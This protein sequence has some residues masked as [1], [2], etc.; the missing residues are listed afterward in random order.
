MD[1]TVFGVI[2]G[3]IGTVAGAA[4][5]YFGPLQ[6]ERRRERSE[7]AARMEAKINADIGRYVAARAAADQWLDLLRRGHRAVL[8]S[9]L[10]L[11]QFDADVVRH[12]DEL[13]LRL[14][15][16]AHIGM[17]D[18]RTNPTFSSFRRASDAI[19]RSAIT[20]NAMSY[21]DDMETAVDRHIEACAAERTRW[22][23]NVLDKL[24][25]EGMDRGAV[26]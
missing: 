26:S 12:S 22:A 20:R 18:S 16:L 17:S 10:D 9:R 24:S 1:T 3:L 21:E 6:L 11:D 2:C 25:R 23:R 13:R 19:R 7:R 5:A 4:V 8:E 15:D 14:A